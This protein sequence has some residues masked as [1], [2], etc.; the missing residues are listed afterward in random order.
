[1]TQ[2]PPNTDAS[3]AND[4]SPAVA[5]NKT[6]QDLA[7][8]ATASRPKEARTRRSRT[9]LI[10]TWGPVLGVACAMAAV[11]SI[12]VRV[13]GLPRALLPLPSEV[14]EAAWAYRVEL[15]QG[16][17]TTG[18]ASLAGLIAAIAIGCLISVAFSQS[19]RIR[20]AFFPYVVFLQ[21]V[22]I[23]AIAP[24]LITWSGY[25]FR[26]VVIVTV[27]VCLF[28]V[29]NSVTAGL[30]AVDR[31]WVDLFRLYGASRAQT[32][33][34]LQIPTAIEYLIIG[35]K[36]SSGL[37]VIGAIVAEFFVGNGSG[38]Q[39]D[40]LGTLM[41]HWQGFVKTDALIA[42]VFASTLL[43]LGLFAMVQLASVTVLSRWMR[44]TQSGALRNDRTSH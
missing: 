17:L 29:V 34:K 37:A 2:P 30:T 11:W 1:M 28:P 38:N 44:H 18:L 24:L 39:Y 14:V 43:G 13:F 36:T 6:H 20:L 26:T 27:I 25:E 7:M 41:T 12:V 16:F 22:P 19:R 3:S 32:L 31:A 5:A 35:S 9:K 8:R 33:V 15:W 40:G 4:E 21:T 42:A 10:G 23:V